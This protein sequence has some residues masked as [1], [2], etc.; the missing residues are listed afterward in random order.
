MKTRASSRDTGITA[1]L[2][3]L[4]SSV[5]CG[6]RRAR[7]DLSLI[8]SDRRSSAAAVFTRNLVVAA[9]I[10]A[11]REALG[12]SGGHA[13]AIVVNSGNANA[14]TG[15]HGLAAAR[16]TARA[17]ARLLHISDSEVL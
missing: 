17:T 8:V 1:P 15:D 3:F 4:A 9:P 5:A 2:G 14:C 12:A 6:I 13:R 11:C 7:P 16:E 10:V